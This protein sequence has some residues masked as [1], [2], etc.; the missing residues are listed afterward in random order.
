MLLTYEQI[1]SAFELAYFIC[2]GPAM[3]GIGILALRQISVSK[4]IA[5]THSKREAYKIAAEQNKFYTDHVIAEYTHLMQ[6]IIN[7][8]LDEPSE[9]D[10]SVSDGKIITTAKFSDEDTSI[11]M[12]HINGLIALVN[13]IDVFSTYF[14]SGIADEELAYSMSGRVFIKKIKCL[15]PIIQKFELSEGYKHTLDL[16][17]MW[18]TRAKKERLHKKNSEIQSQ[19]DLIKETN[20]RPIGT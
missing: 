4:E 15:Y 2:G 13:K 12:S 5:R 14:T 8:G 3:L 9:D 18:E 19:L 16:F 17:I 1:R 11:L 6:A 7:S 10:T 20:I